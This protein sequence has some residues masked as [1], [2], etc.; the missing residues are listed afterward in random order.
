MS[1]LVVSESHALGDDYVY[2]PSEE[3]FEDLQSSIDR[4]RKSISIRVTETVL[5]SKI[6]GIKKELDKINNQFSAFKEQ[7]E[8][9]FNDGQWK[10]T[11]ADEIAESLNAIENRY[12]EIDAA[13]DAK[14]I[15]LVEASAIEEKVKKIFLAQENKIRAIIQE[16]GKKL[17]AELDEKLRRAK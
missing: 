12:K 10:K 17:K 2:V 14:M 13:L 16:E 15:K 1:E 4:L 8:S 9:V 6:D 7:I 5:K 11:F 3:D